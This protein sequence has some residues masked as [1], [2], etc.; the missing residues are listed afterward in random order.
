[1]QGFDIKI[2]IE[3][4][5]RS[6]SLNRSQIADLNRAARAAMGQSIKV[7]PGDV[8]RSTHGLRLVIQSGTEMYGLISIKSFVSDGP[9]GHHV[10]SKSMTTQELEDYIL[11]KNYERV[12]GISE[13]NLHAVTKDT[14]L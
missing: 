10:A 11:N 8:F 13:L 12:G 7:S 3:T 1:M 6:K 2:F 9:V 5:A 14:K 4:L